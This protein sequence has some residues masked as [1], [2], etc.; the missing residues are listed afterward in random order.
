MDSV[1]PDT[2]QW[3]GQRLSAFQLHLEHLALHTVVLCIGI[4]G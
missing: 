3:Q 4:A 2:I 1:T